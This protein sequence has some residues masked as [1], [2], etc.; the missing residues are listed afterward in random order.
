[1]SIADEIERIGHTITAAELAD[2]LAIS[3]VTVFKLAAAGRIRSFR[4][5]SC[6]RFDPRA[7]A[8]WLRKVRPRLTVEG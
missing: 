3:R 6:V 4:G 7:V 1:M 2:L 5:G 8:N